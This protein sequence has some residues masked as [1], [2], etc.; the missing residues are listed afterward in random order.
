I[1][2][3][4]DLLAQIMEK[5]AILEW[6]TDQHAD[7]ISGKAQRVICNEVYTAL[8]LDLIKKFIHA[9][10]N[11]LPQHLNRLGR[12]EWIEQGTQAIMAWR[13]AEQHVGAMI[14]EKRAFAEPLAELVVLVDRPGKIAPD[15]AY[16]L[17]ARD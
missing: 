3:I 8:R 13:I 17:I 2:R 10:F 14:F 9:L 12:K 11:G 16:V 4:D 5:E 1:Q 6:Q 15:R 7:Y